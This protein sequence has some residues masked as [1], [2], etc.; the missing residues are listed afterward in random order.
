MTYYRK[1]TDVDGE[2]KP[3]SY[4]PRTMEHYKSLVEYY[5][6]QW[7][8]YYSYTILPAASMAEAIF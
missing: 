8:N 4:A 6:G 5:E 2:W 7:G 1:R 3:L